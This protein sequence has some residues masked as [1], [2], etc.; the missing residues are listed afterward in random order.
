[1]ESLRSYSPSSE[2]QLLDILNV[3]DPYLDSVHLPV[4]TATMDVFLSLST[5]GMSTVSS[6]SNFGSSI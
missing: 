2:A 5:Q 4:V 3:I 6:D 1:M